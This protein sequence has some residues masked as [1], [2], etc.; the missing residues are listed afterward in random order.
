[1]SQPVRVRFAPSPTGY[2]HIGGVRTALFNWLFAQKSGGQFLL[3]IEDTDQKRFVP[4]GEEQIKKSL[5]WLGLTW[6]PEVVRQSERVK[7]GTYTMHALQLVEQGNAY[8][9]N[10]S[11]EEIAARKE[12]WQS[13]PLLGKP[14]L[15]YDSR[16][17]PVEVADYDPSLGHVI[18]Y[19]WPD[20]IPPMPVI[21]FE[22]GEDPRRWGETTFDVLTAPSSFED[23]ILIKSDS[24]PTYNFAHV[25]D[26]H[27]QA[28]THVIR[29]DEFTSSAN[30][31]QQLYQDFRWPKPKYV[32]IPPILGPDGQKKLSK[33]AGSKNT[34]E[35]R[36]EGYL[37]EAIAN[38]ISLIG[39]NPGG[40]R[41][42][43]WSLEELVEAFSLEGLQRSPGRFD[44]QKVRWMNKEHLKR[45]DLGELMA[46]A[47]ALGS[48]PPGAARQDLSVFKVALERAHTLRDL[49]LDELR[50]FQQAPR[51]TVT[52][53]VGDAN[54]ATVAGWLER[55]TRFLETVTDWQQDRL[56]GA[57]TDLL[58]E[59][60]LQP[61]QLFPV[62][63]EALTG[64]PQT[65]ALWEVMDIL[66][67]PETLRR[68]ET[69]Q[70]LVA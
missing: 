16:E 55:T 70:A 38:F 39:W 63:R 53:L 49:N 21:Y 3:R 66:G 34:Q 50:Y 56:Q 44:D 45:R 64:A 8:I 57:L 58:H 2:L 51:L 29:G 27:D 14:P 23:F 46:L 33:R 25:I 13:L 9:A 48:W 5:A 41:E 19:R 47:T 28:I 20:T 17:K 60:D 31:Y 4:E 62:L 37:P 1:M 32:H 10:D 26:D 61:K 42:L 15:R 35:Y 11:P 68:L 18:R 67:K 59:L 54:P 69:A 52:Q 36:D 43:F 22:V 12:S 6:E 65:P 40:D 30:K 24:F 7:T